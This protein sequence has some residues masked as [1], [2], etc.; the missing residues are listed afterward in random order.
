VAGQIRQTLEDNEFGVEPEEVIT[1]L[2]ST[3]NAPITGY[4]KMIWTVAA[5]DTGHWD[6][7]LSKARELLIAN[8]F[9]EKNPNTPI[10]VMLFDVP[11]THYGHIEK[12]RQ[13]AGGLLAA[14]QWLVWP[15]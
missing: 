7:D 11:M 10:R 14:L 12:P 15:E 3:M 6:K 5:A 9:R 2:F 13:V 8:E 4:N 1:D